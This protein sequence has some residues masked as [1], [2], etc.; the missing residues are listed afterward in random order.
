MKGT[1]C[2]GESKIQFFFKALH[3]NYNVYDWTSEHIS[4]VTL[5]FISRESL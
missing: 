2:F 3:F 1:L 4:F 5:V